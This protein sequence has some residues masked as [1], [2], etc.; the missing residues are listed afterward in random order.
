[1]LS[2]QPSHPGQGCGC[3]PVHRAV[4]A[5]TVDAWY[6]YRAFPIPIQVV[7]TETVSNPTLVVADLPALAHIAHSHVRSSIQRML[8]MSQVS[9]EALSLCMALAR[10]AHPLLWTTHSAP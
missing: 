10:R 3:K 8:S 4:Q 9:P 1:M 7:Y 5:L 6:D 2:L